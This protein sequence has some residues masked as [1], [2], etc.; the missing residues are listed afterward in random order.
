MIFILK[1]EMIKEVNVMP[2][3]KEII[4]ISTSSYAGYSLPVALEHILKIGFKQVEIA[5]TSGQVEH[6]SS[7]DFNEKGANRINQL[8]EQNGL[9]NTAFSGHIFISNKNAV[10]VFKPRMEFTKAIGAKIINTKA[11]PISEI[12]SFYKNL[13]KLVEF[14]EE[15]KIKIGLET[16]ADIVHDGV[17]GLDVIEKF[18]SDFLVLTYD[19]GNVFVNSGGRVD[20]AVEFEKIS[21]LIG[22]IHLKD[23]L[24]EN[25]TDDFWKMCAVGDGMVNYDQILKHLRQLKNPISTTIELPF[26]IKMHESGKV[27]ILS[28]YMQLF[29]IDKIL[30]KS[31]RYVLNVLSN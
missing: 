23:V 24:K 18:S 6:V 29:E 28:D 12:K 9:S 26:C 4:A 7:N 31:Y 8:L 1:N 5:A 20:P 11:G 19:C 2:D 13:E 15:I 16:S 21:D 10:D 3:Y 17:S 14:A 22:H 27:K 30:K 25:G